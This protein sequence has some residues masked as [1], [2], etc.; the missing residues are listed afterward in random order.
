MLMFSELSEF[1]QRH[2][3]NLIDL[4]NECAIVY[5]GYGGAPRVLLLGKRFSIFLNN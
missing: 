2:L 5:E 1:Y 3:E 4:E